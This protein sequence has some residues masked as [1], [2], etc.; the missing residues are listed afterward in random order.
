MNSAIVNGMSRSVEVLDMMGLWGSGGERSSSLGTVAQSLED[1][2]LIPGGKSDVAY[3]KRIHF[4]KLLASGGSTSAVAGVD[5]GSRLLSARERLQ[6]AS[7]PASQNTVMTMAIQN[8]PE[9]L[10]DLLVLLPA[11]RLRTSVL[12]KPPPHLTEMALAALRQN[13]LPAERPEDDNGKTSGKKRKVGS[14]GGDSSDEEDGALGS[15]G[16]GTQFRA[17][18]RARMAAPSNGITAG[19]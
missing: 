9:W 1:D 15:G 6:G 8:S 3:Q 14:G 18:Q 11:S 10:R 16:Y 7:V 2:E 5:A 17:R 12:S 13:K 19:N 4:A